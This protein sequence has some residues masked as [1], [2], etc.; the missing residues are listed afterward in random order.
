LVLVIRLLSRR[1]APDLVLIEAAQAFAG[2]KAFFDGPSPPG[3]GD[4]HAQRR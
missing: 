3:H 1:P 4:Q 2:L